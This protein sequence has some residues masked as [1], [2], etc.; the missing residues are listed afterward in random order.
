MYF[1]WDGS[2]IHDYQEPRLLLY[3]NHDRHK[4]AKGTMKIYTKFQIV[5]DDFQFL[6]ENKKKCAPNSL[7]S[8][9]FRLINV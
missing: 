2:H 7:R 1:G 4:P 5:S 9:L 8:N 6:G 3:L